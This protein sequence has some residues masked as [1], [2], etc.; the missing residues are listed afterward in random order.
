M[1]SIHNIQKFLSNYQ[2]LIIHIVE[3]KSILNIQLPFKGFPGVAGLQGPKGQRGFPGMEGL[4]G[5][6][7][8]K[9]DPGPPGLRGLKGDPG[10]QGKR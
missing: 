9:G 8:D 3:I 10:K 6:K 5:P 2:L 7:G 4:V 1:K